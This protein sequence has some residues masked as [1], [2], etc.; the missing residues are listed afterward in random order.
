MIIPFFAELSDLVVSKQ[1]CIAGH[2]GICHSPVDKTT[3]T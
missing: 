3:N 1:N 2:G